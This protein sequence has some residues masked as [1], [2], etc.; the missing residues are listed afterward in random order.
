MTIY[1]ASLWGMEERIA[2]NFADAW[3]YIQF[4]GS[5]G[6]WTTDGSQ[7]ADYQHRPT[8][9]MREHLEAVVRMARENPDDADI[10]DQIEAA[11]EAMTESDE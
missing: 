4:E 7:V 1:T 10:A 3:S 6:Q 9:A 5:D 11:V 2:A 8:N